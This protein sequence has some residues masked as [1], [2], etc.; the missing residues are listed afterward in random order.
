MN[1]L[2][3]LRDINKTLGKKIIELE[4]YVFI[5]NINIADDDDEEEN[6]ISNKNNITNYLYKRI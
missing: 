4:T 3:T 6:I 5:E 1:K 2:E